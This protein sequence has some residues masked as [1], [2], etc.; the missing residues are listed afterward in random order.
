MPLLRLLTIAVVV[1]QGIG[2]AAAI[3]RIDPAPAQPA[4]FE[5]DVM[6]ILTA[7]GCNQG[8]CHGKS[9]GQNGFQLSLLGFDSQ[10]DFGAIVLEGRGRRVSPA[11]PDESLLLAKASAR[12]PHGGG[13]RLPTDSEHYQTLRQWIA[14]GMHRNPPDGPKLQQITVMPAES[15]LSLGESLQLRVMANYSDQSS[16]D[17]TRLCAYQS[18]EAAVAAVNNVGLIHAG[19]LSGEASIMIRYMGQILSWNV[20]I[21]LSQRLPAEQYARLPRSNFID[22]HVWRKLEK[23]GVLPS[24][25]AGDSTFLRRVY[26]DV[27]GRL[28]TVDEVRAFHADSA[29]DKRTRLVDALLARPEY[30][31]SW[32]NRWVDLLRPNPYRVGMKATLNFDTWIRDQFRRNAPYDQFVRELI[33]AR[34][35]TW[36]NGAVTLLRDRRTP[37]EITPLVCQLFMGIRIDCARCHHH[38]FEVWGQD[39]FYRLAAYFS[40]IGYKGTG[41]SPPISGGEEIV[42]HRPTGN[43]KHPLTGEVVAPRPLAG[44]AKV[45]TNDDPRDVFARWLTADDN[46]Y[47][48]RAAVNRIWAEL[49]GRGLVEPVD[50]LRATNPATNDPLLNALAAEFRRNGYDQKQL[51]RIILTSYVYGL[52]SQPNETNV[53]DTQNYSRHYRTRLRAETILDAV[54]DICGVGE[55]FAAMPPGSRSVELW[56]HR[57]PSL[58]LDAFGRPDPNQDPPC[59][60]TTETAMVQ[61]LHLMNAPQL[62][63]KITGDQSLPARLIVA[64]APPAQ[65]IETLYLAVFS[66]PPTSDELTA[67]LPIYDKD[68]QHRARPPK[69]CCGPCSIRQNSCSKIDNGVRAW[70][71]IEIAKG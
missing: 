43:V 65:I 52:S 66:R 12:I 19:K 25:S 36:Q 10:F 60:R 14:D 27:I 21:P 2:S 8:A 54:C 37:E 47:F 35:S 24:P 46:P 40:Q 16:R 39:E 29:P 51:L 9:R 20:V 45:E 38:P 31:D 32:A 68:E 6:P 48:G 53:A 57:V 11:A 15:P 41:L 61:T 1:L 50:D 70:R 64:K 59:E 28:P 58:T 62:H 49:M 30:A 71:S 69:T 22:D 56:T 67:V 23:V 7:A 63:A 5:L 34:G 4:N 13:L 42:F 3:E 55:Q 17:V 33:T 18:S 26:L 44:S